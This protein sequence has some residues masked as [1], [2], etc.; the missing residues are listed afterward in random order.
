MIKLQLKLHAGYNLS[1][2]GRE[3]ILI[4]NIV[5]NINKKQLFGDSL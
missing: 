2:C 1:V 4:N 3:I 5:A